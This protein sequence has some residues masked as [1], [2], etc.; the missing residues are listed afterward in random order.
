MTEAIFMCCILPPGYLTSGRQNRYL[1][2]LRRTAPFAY[3]KT[4][5]R[6]AGGRPVVAIQLGCGATRSC[7]AA[8]TTPTSRSR[9]HF[10]GSCCLLTAAPSAKTA[11]SAAN[12]PARSTAIRCST[13]C[14]LS[15]RTARTSSRAK[16]R[17]PR[18]S[19]SLP[20]S[21]PPRIRNFRFLPAGRRTCG[22]SI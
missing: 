20:R 17:T 14:R 21:L 8:R 1:R 16:F 19:I 13:A 2:Q 12:L 6:T 18:P 4:L 10:S 3:V 11:A 15:T 22:A 5:T 7:S 9:A